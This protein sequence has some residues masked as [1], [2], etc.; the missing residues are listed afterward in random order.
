LRRIRIDREYSC[1]YNGY[2]KEGTL[3]HTVGVRELKNR[4]TYYLGLAKKGNNVVVTDRGVPV[5][6]LHALDQREEATGVEERLAS[7]AK[8]GFLALPKIKSSWPSFRRARV[9][10]VPVS[11]T[12][13]QDRK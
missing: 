1:G 11:E 12:L 9:K 7:L 3:L 2:K 4:V 10:G 6:I 8:E 5:A 13:I